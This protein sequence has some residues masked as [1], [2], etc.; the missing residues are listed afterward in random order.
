MTKR[1]DPRRAKAHLTY[2]AGELCIVFGVGIGS[3]RKWHKDGL[4]PIDRA[5]P[6]LYAGSEV[7]SFLA[8]RNKPREPMSPGHIYCVACKAPVF[9]ADG[10]VDIVARTPTSKDIRG[11][12][13]TCGR[14]IFRRVRISELAA[15]L[16]NLRVR[17]EDV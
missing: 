2:T 4:A 8:A 3:I 1:Y 7:A 12:C 17:N 13:P 16:G 10:V 5:R 15:K 14:R 9:P 6:F 11:S